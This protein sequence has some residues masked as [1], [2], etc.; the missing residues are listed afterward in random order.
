MALKLKHWNRIVSTL[1]TEFMNR[2][3]ND[4]G[5]PS[6]LANLFMS[7]LENETEKVQNYNNSLE[8]SLDM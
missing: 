2:K 7:R 4:Y 1:P 3:R 6:L 8:Y 5:L